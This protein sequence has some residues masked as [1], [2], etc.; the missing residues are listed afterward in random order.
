MTIQPQLV[1]GAM[2]IFVL[3]PFEGTP[4]FKAGIRP[5]DQILSVDGKSTDGLD[6]SAVAALLKGPR[7]THVLVT[8]SRE[9][10]D[11]PLSFDLV[12]DEIPRPSVDLAFMIQPG[13][14]YMH[15][16]NFQETTRPRGRRRP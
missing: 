1:E 8:M 12:R 7:G 11:K 10:R 6:S 14:G 3:Y 16:T 9:G 15:V 2:K 13:I 4:S 5:G